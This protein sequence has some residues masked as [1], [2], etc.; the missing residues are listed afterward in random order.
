[1]R[2]LSFPHHAHRVLA[3]LHEY[4]DQVV[5]QQGGLYV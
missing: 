1:M 3:V 5:I 2:H 4:M